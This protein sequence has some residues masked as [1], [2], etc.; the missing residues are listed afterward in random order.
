MN[1][2]KLILLAVFAP[3]F[4]VDMPPREAGFYV[5]GA[6]KYSR[7]YRHAPLEQEVRGRRRAYLIARWLALVL[8]FNR[9]TN[10]VGVRWFV[11]RSKEAR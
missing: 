4:F 7:F 3:R 2:F 1:P 6:E 9:C 10:E 8:D 5:A 11:R